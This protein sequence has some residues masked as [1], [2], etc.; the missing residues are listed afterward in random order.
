MLGQKRVH[1]GNEDCGVDA[2]GDAQDLVPELPFT[3]GDDGVL[4]DQLQHLASRRQSEDVVLV[5]FRV[6]A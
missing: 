4:D 3:K 6:R 5:A 2:H 1:V